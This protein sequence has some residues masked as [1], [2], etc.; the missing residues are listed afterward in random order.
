MNRRKAFG[1]IAALPLA[2]KSSETLAGGMAVVYLVGDLPRAIAGQT[3]RIRFLV[4][5]HDM[6]DHLWNGFDAEI[7][8]VPRS[9]GDELIFTVPGAKGDGMSVGM[10]STEIVVPDAGEYK[11]Y[12]RPGSWAPT[13]FPTLVVHESDTGASPGDEFT[14]VDIGQNGFQPVS[15]TVT[16]G[17]TVIWRN[18]DAFSA[19]QVTWTSLD[20]NDSAPIPSGGEYA[21]TFDEPGTYDYYCGPHPHMTGRINVID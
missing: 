9:G 18:T 12:I 6:V 19:H 17:G 2:L 14:L 16:N 1:V 13:Y 10:Y 20:L 4:L 8:L 7:H 21:Y 3:L 15:T 5:G 11:W